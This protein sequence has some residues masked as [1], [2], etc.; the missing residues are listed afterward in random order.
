M[1][2]FADREGV[3]GSVMRIDQADHDLCHHV[4]LIRLAFGNHQRERH[5]RIVRHP[6]DL[7]FYN[8]KGR[9]AS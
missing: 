9:K 7:S 1:R 8:N 5:Q 2:A 4:L 6:S 3:R